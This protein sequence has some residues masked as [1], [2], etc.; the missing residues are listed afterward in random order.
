MPIYFALSVSQAAFAQ[1]PDVILGELVGPR[2]YA[3]ANGIVAITVGT[4][5]CNAGNAVLNWKQLP[6][7]RHPTITLNMYRLLDGRMTQIG[8]SWAKHGFVALQQNICN[9]GCQANP[10]GDGLGIGCSDP[11]GTSNNQGPFLGSRRLI[12]PATGNF[13]G[14]KAMQE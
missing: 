13:D 1:S 7:N 4:T 2:V 8:Q 3:R 9:F 5:S 12:N 6:D 14:V 11:Y 10:S